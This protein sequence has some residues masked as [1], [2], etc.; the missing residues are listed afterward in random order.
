MS[1]VRDVIDSTLRALG[2]QAPPGQL[3]RLEQAVMASLRTSYAGYTVRLYVPRVGT[4]ERA[5]R[6]RA[7][8]ALWNGSNT[9]ALAAQFGISERQV[10]RIVGERAR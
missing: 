2:T 6:A 3:G 7:I 1:F 4:A 5:A 8:R 10:Q 9:A